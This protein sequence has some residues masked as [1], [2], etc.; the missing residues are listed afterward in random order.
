MVSTARP[1]CGRATPAVRRARDSS[2]HHQTEARRKVPPGRASVRRRDG[3]HAPRLGRPRAKTGRR[4]GSHP[5]GAAGASVLRRSLVAC[6]SAR[7][8]HEGERAIGIRRARATSVVSPGRCPRAFAVETGCP[9]IFRADTET[10]GGL[11]DHHRRDEAVPPARPR[12]KSRRPGFSPG[13]AARS[14]SRGWPGPAR[15]RTRTGTFLLEATSVDSTGSFLQ[16]RE[17]HDGSTA[18]PAGR[19]HR[20]SSS[21]SEA[22]ALQRLQLRDD[23]RPFCCA[24]GC[25]P[26]HAA[27]HGDPRQANVNNACSSP[28]WNEKVSR[29]RSASRLSH[30]A[31]RRIDVHTRCARHLPCPIPTSSRR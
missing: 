14:C 12:L 9:A 22:T 6:S 11:A 7:A 23:T 28:T 8:T 1:V 13:A 21:L 4:R 30:V 27:A 24:R 25:C 20:S 17:L 15:C 26:R 5:R 3:S 10:D 2:A 31:S 19:R 16:G 18:V 29:A